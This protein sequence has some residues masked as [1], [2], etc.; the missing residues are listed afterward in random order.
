MWFLFAQRAPDN[1]LMA[2]NP[3]FDPAE[4]PKPVAVGDRFELKLGGKLTKAIVIEVSQSPEVLADLNKQH[5]LYQKMAEEGWTVPP[6]PPESL[7]E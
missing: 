3:S 1:P 4:F 5:W 7:A 2:L 6:E